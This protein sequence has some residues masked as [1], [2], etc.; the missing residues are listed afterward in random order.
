VH[1]AMRG[2]VQDLRQTWHSHNHDQIAQKPRANPKRPLL[3][4]GKNARGKSDVYHLDQN[5]RAHIRT[6]GMNHGRQ[7]DK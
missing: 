1:E 3:Q 4:S 5:N 7:V 2:P 6:T